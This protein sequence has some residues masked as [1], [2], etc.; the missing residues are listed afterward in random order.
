MPLIADS[1]RRQLSR[2]RPTLTDEQRERDMAAYLLC[3]LEDSPAKA[4][5]R[6]MALS[7][8]RE[9]ARTDQQ[10]HDW[11]RRVERETG[12]AANGAR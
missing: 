10:L 5:Q 6:E 9:H 4:A 11:I 2:I 8:I 12:R 1:V 7:L 3:L